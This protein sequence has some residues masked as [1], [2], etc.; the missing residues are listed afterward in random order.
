MEGSDGRALK[1]GV[2]FWR[3]PLDI[4][5]VPKIRGKVTV[6]TELCKGCHY[7]VEFCPAGV[8]EISPGRNSKGYHPPEVKY[9]EKCTGCGFC[10]RVCPDY[11]IISEKVVEEVS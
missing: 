6:F 3:T 11:A 2:L 9:P 4:E 7:C 1:G 5:E 10:E 8:L